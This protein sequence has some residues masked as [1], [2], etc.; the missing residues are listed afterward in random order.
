[1]D[2]NRILIHFTSARMEISVHQQ[3]QDPGELYERATHASRS[4]FCLSLVATLA[5]NVWPPRS[6]SARSQVSTALFMSR[7]CGHGSVQMICSLL[8][9]KQK[10]GDAI[11]V[12]IFVWRS[13]GLPDLLRHPSIVVVER[14]QLTNT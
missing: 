12:K 7:L 5:E 4:E 2:C 1:M 14:T 6:K 10:V 3:F 11:S 9:C 13:L 8:A